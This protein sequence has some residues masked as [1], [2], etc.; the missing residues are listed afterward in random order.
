MLQ[1]TSWLSRKGFA[2][3]IML[4]DRVA[5]LLV[6]EAEEQ[7]EAAQQL[8]EPLVDQRLRHEDQHAVGAAREMQAMQDQPRL[9][10]LAEAH[11]IRQQHARHEPRGDLPGDEHLVRQQIH[12][13]ADEAAHRRLPD[14]AAPVQRLDAQVEGAQVVHLPGRAAGP[15]AC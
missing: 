2:V 1:R 9:D 13:P 3:R 8:H 6:E 12:A 15:P 10:R 7:I 5:A 11:L 4:L 14:A